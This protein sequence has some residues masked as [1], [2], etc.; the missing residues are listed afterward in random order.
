MKDD[1]TVR[2]LQRV[3]CSH[4][5]AIAMDGDAGGNSVTAHKCHDVS[6]INVKLKWIF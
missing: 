5:R 2:K 1:F 3:V 4:Q 6:S